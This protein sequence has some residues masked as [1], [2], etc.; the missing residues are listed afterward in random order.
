MKFIKACLLLLLLSAS[1][2]V[3]AVTDSGSFSESLNPPSSYILCNLNNDI[4]T[5]LGSVTENGNFTHLYRF[6]LISDKYGGMA[7]RQLDYPFNTNF[8]FGHL[9]LSSQLNDSA[10]EFIED[11]NTSKGG[12]SATSTSSSNPVFGN[13]TLNIPGNSTGTKSD[14]YK[15]SMNGSVESEP[16]HLIIMVVVVLFLV[17]MQVIKAKKDTEPLALKAV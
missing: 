10:F 16:E 5:C 4:Y 11:D 12:T 15:M 9:K 1:S 6:T 13:H 14:N 17:G 3:V 7:G 2:L 8:N